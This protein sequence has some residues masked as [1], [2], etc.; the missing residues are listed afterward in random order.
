MKNNY[1]PPKKKT[2]KRVTLQ[3]FFLC[4][5]HYL[6]FTIFNLFLLRCNCHITVNLRRTVCWS[7][8]FTYWNMAASV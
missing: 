8:T 4:V 3:I 5:T 6:H 2:V 1:L 7:D